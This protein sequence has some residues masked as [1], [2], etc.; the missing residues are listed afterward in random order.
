[1]PVFSIAATVCPPLA[2]IAIDVLSRSSAALGLSHRRALVA[3]AVR[4]AGR[5]APAA[6]GGN[7]RNAGQVVMSAYLRR[8][9][10]GAGAPRRRA[11]TLDT[12]WRRWTPVSGERFKTSGRAEPS[13]PMTGLSGHERPL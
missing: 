3:R 11:R 7:Q 10:I 12:L 6:A 4:C 5:A 8:W 13:G 9:L 1:M 2:L